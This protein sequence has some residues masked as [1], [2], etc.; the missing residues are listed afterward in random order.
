MLITEMDYGPHSEFVPLSGIPSVVVALSWPFVLLNAGGSANPVDRRRVTLTKTTK[1]YYEGYFSIAG[2]APAPDPTTTQSTATCPS[3]GGVM[4]V[5]LSP[6]N[7]A[8]FVCP[9]CG[10]EGV[11]H[12]AD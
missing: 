11:G 10:I 6:N 5:L 9:H 2:R 3:C 12:V 4:R 1:E 7:M 8:R